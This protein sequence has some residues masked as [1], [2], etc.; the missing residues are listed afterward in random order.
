[1]KYNN[2]VLIP[3][4]ILKRNDINRRDI[5]DRDIADDLKEFDELIG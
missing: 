1:M 5:Y 4:S 3:R 2:D